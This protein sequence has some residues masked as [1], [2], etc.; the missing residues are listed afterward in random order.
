ME[1]S[2]QDQ[3]GLL[4]VVE[5]AAKIRMVWEEVAKTHCCRPSE[6]V[7]AAYAAASGRWDVPLDERTVTLSSIWIGKSA[8][9][10]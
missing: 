2:A 9:W 10:E 4:H 1:R 7:K 3:A 8:Y 6:E 5:Q